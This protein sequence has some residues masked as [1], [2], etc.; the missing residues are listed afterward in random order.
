M[1]NRIKKAFKHIPVMS[2]VVLETDSTGHFLNHSTT[3]QVDGQMALSRRGA[4]YL[5]EV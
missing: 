3:Q 2:F 4:L 1:E 5:C